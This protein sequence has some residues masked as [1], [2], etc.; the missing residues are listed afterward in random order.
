MRHKLVFSGGEGGGSGS[1]IPESTQKD[2]IGQEPA[3]EAEE[4]AGEGSLVEDSEAS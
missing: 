3:F 4:N 2:I 1:G